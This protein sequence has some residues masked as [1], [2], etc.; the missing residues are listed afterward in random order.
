MRRPSWFEPL[1]SVG[2]WIGFIGGI[3]V[4]CGIAAM[5]VFDGDGVSQLLCWEPGDSCGYSVYR[6]RNDLDQ[7]I[8]VRECMHH[9]GTGDQ[10]LD[11]IAVPAGRVTQNSFLA[12]SAIVGLHDWWEVKSASGEVLGC[13]VLDG[14]A[15][16]HDGDLVVVSAAG[17]C[18]PQAAVTPFVPA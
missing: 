7:P 6:I 2:E 5:F 12:V 11:P 3:A 4:V 14:H 13:L 16:K 17:P 15:H 9:C 8:V 10:R 18:T 1:D